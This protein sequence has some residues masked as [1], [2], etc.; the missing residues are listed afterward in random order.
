MG[1]ILAPAGRFSA[2]KHQDQI[3]LTDMHLLEGGVRFPV[4][5]AELWRQHCCTGTIL[6]VFQRYII[7]VLCLWLRIQQ[8]LYNRSDFPCSRVRS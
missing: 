1:S 8:G 3:S 5:A 2:D 7:W 4:C 6:I